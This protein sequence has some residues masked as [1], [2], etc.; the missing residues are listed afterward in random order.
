MSQ[1]RPLTDALRR[2]KDKVR[3]RTAALVSEN[4]PPCSGLN[5]APSSAAPPP[6]LGAKVAV[7]GERHPRALPAQS[8]HGAGEILNAG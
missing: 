8:I 7:V 6:M 5:P 1:T 2:S 3:Y 4:R